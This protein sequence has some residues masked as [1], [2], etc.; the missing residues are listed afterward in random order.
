[1]HVF[2]VLHCYLQF[3]RR[4]T[5]VPQANSYKVGQYAFVLFH[6]GEATQRAHEEAV[7]LATQGNR[8]EDKETRDA[9]H[10]SRNSPIPGFNIGAVVAMAVSNDEL[11]P[12]Y[13]SG[14]EKCIDVE[15]VHVSLIRPFLSVATTFQIKRYIHSGEVWY[16]TQRVPP[17]EQEIDRFRDKLIS[18]EL[19][20]KTGH[21]E[22]SRLNAWILDKV[23]Q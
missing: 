21:L 6:V 13:F 19:C 9:Y 12:V 15:Y 8:G 18:G 10:Q 14:D 17:A 16:A 3:H 20:Y 1:M 5:R 7:Q 23:S 2:V 22:A 4:S 11:V